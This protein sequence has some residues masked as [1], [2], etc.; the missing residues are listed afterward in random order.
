MARL[1]ALVAILTAAGC[2]YD[3]DSV[4]LVVSDTGLDWTPPDQIISPDLLPC[5]HPPVSPDC[6][7]GYCH[8]PAGCF[9]MGSPEQDK[10]RE[11]TFKIGS[12]DFTVRETLHPVTLT[13]GFLIGQHE[14]TQRDFE[15][16]MS[17]NPVQKK[18]HIAKCNGNT[19]QGPI[20]YPA[21]PGCLDCPVACLTWHEAQAYCNALSKAFNHA[22]CFDCQGTDELTIC[23]VKPEYGPEGS[24]KIYDCPGYRL[25]T[26][27]EWEY[28]YRAGSDTAVYPS[29]GSDG[30]VKTC[31]GQDEN[32]DRIAWYTDNSGGEAHEVGQKAPNAWGLLDMAGNSWEWCHDW[33]PDDLGSDPKTD[34]SGQNWVGNGKVVRGGSFQEDPREMRA[35]HRRPIHSTHFHWTMSFRCVRSLVSP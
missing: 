12:Y 13:H 14:V 20:P 27:A 3:W 19:G 16:W 9:A 25:P 2:V 1:L 32:V 17:Y 29:Q 23:T 26:E 15:S 31:T 7:D 22:Q 30:S 6:K 34:P 28:A 5:P 4:P 21:R 35:A 10:C 18:N 24:S 8:I 33:Y 11:M